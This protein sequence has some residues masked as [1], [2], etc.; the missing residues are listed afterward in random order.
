M[1]GG[2]LRQTGIL[3]AAGLIAIEK[4]PALLHKDHEA[5]KIIAG[6]FSNQQKT[7]KPQ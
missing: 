3:A 1:L 2:G 4:M 7:Y 5:A 6:K